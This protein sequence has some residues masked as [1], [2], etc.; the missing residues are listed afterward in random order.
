MMREAAMLRKIRAGDPAGL[1]G[2]MTAY[3][4]YVSVIV[5]NILRGAMP[6]EDGEEVVSDVFLAAW[7]QAT[8]L[9]AGHVKGWLGAVARNKARNKLRQAGRTLPLEENLLELPDSS[10][11]TEGLTREE[12]RVQVRQA[13]EALPETDREIFLHHYYY[14]Q[15]VREIAEAMK[16]KEPTVKTRLR[17]G[18]EK[19]KAMLTKGDETGEA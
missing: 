16:L 7:D 3:L 4:P 8:D 17:R 9:R 15:T 18:R 5:W 14:A 1:E 12:E 13:V 11:P 19:L 2:L 6:P 10:D